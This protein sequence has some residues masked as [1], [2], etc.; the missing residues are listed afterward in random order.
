M[1]RTVRWGLAIGG[2]GA[3]ALDL[4]LGGRGGALGLLGLLTLSLALNLWLLPRALG[5][6]FGSWR[7][8]LPRLAPPPGLRARAREEAGA[9]ARTLARA[10]EGPPPTLP[11]E[12]P[13]AFRCPGCGRRLEREAVRCAGCG[14]PARF[15][16]PYCAREVDPGWRRCPACRAALPAAWEGNR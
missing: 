10:L 9:V 4:A 16:C 3:I 15:H 6:A 7:P 5:R 12:P 13:V 14:Q 8:R 11:S 2:L 1:L